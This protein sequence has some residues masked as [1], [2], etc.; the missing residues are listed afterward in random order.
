MSKEITK[1]HKNRRVDYFLVAHGYKSGLTVKELSER[2]NVSTTTIY[3]SLK[4]CGV[5]LTKCNSPALKKARDTLS[6][7]YFTLRW[8]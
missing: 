6:P 1:P 7:K 4:K 2:F 3:A 5:T 8:L